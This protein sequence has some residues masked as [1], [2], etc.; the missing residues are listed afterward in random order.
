MR[1]RRIT[2]VATS[3][4]M[5]VALAPAVRSAPEGLEAERSRAREIESR[6]EE[7]GQRL[8]IADEEYNQAVLER[9][10][11]DRRLD[12]TRDTLAE[13]EERWDELKT[14]LAER[15]RVLYKHPGSAVAAYLNSGSV[16]ELARSQ[17]LADSVLADDT[18][19]LYETEKARQEVRSRASELRG[20]LAVAKEKE[21]ELADRR[22]SVAA[23]VAA[24]QELLQEVQGEIQAVEA[25]RQ[26]ELAE[27]AARTEAAAETPAP[28]PTD[29]PVPTPDTDEAADTVEETV[30]E[31]EPTPTPR[32]TA[33]PTPEPT[34]A[35]SSGGDSGG[36]SGPAPHPKA[37]TAVA[38]AQ[39]QLGKPYRWAAG[40]PDAFDCSGLTSYA[41]AAAGVSLPHSSRAQY[42]SLPKV[43]KSQVRPGDLLFYGS[44]IHHVGIYEG[45]GV[46]IE[47]PYTGAN[48]RRNS[49]HRSDFAGA[50][51]PR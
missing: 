19:L 7:Q 44:P 12:A 49:I 45:N 36:G 22:E 4:A 47:A 38:T 26:R 31:A 43:S 35:P 14:R 33:E 2:A 6:I 18:E 29:P 3:L 48:V 41:W 50:A 23:E 13:A 46:M 30:E 34:P 1:I 16:A 39:D 11:L 37:S 27:A 20:L 51:R 40:G 28:E 32:P 9:R 15:V 42:A 8:S 17:A 25:E 21:G 5:L 10:R 24:Q